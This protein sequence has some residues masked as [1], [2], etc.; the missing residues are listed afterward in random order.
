MIF[1]SP[2]CAT[3]PPWMSWFSHFTE[4]KRKPKFLK[5][6]SSS[7]YPFHFTILL[8]AWTVQFCSRG[9]IPQVTEVE[10]LT[11]ASYFTEEIPLHLVYK[12][13]FL[14]SSP[15]S[16][17]INFL[18]CDW[19]I[20]SKLSQ[21]NADPNRFAFKKSGYD[22]HNIL[23]AKCQTLR[24]IK[25]KEQADEQKILSAIKGTD[26]ESFTVNSCIS[27]AMDLSGSASSINLIILLS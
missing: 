15:A 9:N 24:T 11:H 12:L 4:F 2:L 5:K 13:M 26:W 19:V 10:I 27:S 18:N 6:L 1:F 20:S 25:D 22:F 23:R 16:K 21:K 7:S 3:H 14:K 8:T 17:H